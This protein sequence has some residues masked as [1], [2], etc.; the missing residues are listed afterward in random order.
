MKFNQSLLLIVFTFL[1]I[2]SFSQDMDIYKR[3]TN[4]NFKLPLLK[5]NLTRN[6]FQLL[7]RNARMMDMTYALI[8]PGYIHFKAK[9]NEMAFSLLTARLLGYA[10]LISYINRKNSQINDLTLRDALFNTDTIYKK[11]RNLLVSS[12]TVVVSSYLF[13]WI[14][15]KLRLEKKQELIRY[16]Y[17][18]KM[19]MEKTAQK[20]NVFVPSFSVKYNF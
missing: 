5:E 7:S 2:N 16:R 18:I 1:V 8:V 14:H 10:G 11:D 4:D 20:S 6:E 19:E 13:D 12:I 9:D 15:G 3:S 17:S